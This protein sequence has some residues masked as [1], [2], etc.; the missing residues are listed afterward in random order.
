[1]IN[2]QQKNKKQCRTRGVKLYDA[3]F[4]LIILLF[5]FFIYYVLW[6]NT[7]LIQTIDHGNM[8]NNTLLDSTARISPENLEKRCNQELESIFYSTGR[9][10]SNRPT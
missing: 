9:S 6:S 8:I 4:L 5:L 3:I 10:G 1:M 2:K 7:T